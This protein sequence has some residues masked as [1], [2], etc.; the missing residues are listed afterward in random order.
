MSDSWR[1][2]VELYA[3]GKPIEFPLHGDPGKSDTWVWKFRGGVIPLGFVAY[4]LGKKHRTIQR[5]AAA[6]LIPGCRP[7]N[8]RRPMRGQ[9]HYVIRHCVEFWEWLQKQD[10][11]RDC[12]ET[13]REAET[14][15]KHGLTI[16]HII[17]LEEKCSPDEA[18]E[19]MRE[20]YGVMLERLPPDMLKKVEGTSQWETGIACQV[21]EWRVT[22]TMPKTGE[23]AGRRMW[24]ETWK[25]FLPVR[26]REFVH[27]FHFYRKRILGESGQ[28]EQQ[29]KIKQT[30]NAKQPSPEA[31][32]YF[33][34]T[35]G[36]VRKVIEECKK[37]YQREGEDFIANLPPE[38]RRALNLPKRGRQSGQQ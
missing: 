26:R 22:D 25:S 24:E 12:A 20:K 32:E 38:Y 28:P 23:E 13:W 35:L 10:H 19:R 6:R 18:F 36:E 30:A 33:Q 34:R 1:K 29:E 21:Y 37:E 7:R 2:K 16:E 3:N 8:R 15:R 11:A 17:A 9:P 14:L 4:T 5:W 27:L 31:D